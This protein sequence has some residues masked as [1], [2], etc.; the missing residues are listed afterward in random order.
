MTLPVIECAP[1]GPYLV[2]NLVRLRNS[3]G[4]N[5]A[6]KPVAALCRCGRSSTKPYCDGTHKTVGF[7]GAR[8]KGGGAPRASYA[9]RRLTIH[10]NRGICAH[11]GY[12]TEGVRAVFASGREPWI[13]P[14]GASVEKIIAVIEQCPS[15]ALS[16]S[17]DGIE[18]RDQARAPSI[19][20]TESGPY[21]VVGGAQLVGAEITRGASTEH[22]TLCRCGAS[23]NKPFCDGSHWDIGFKDEAD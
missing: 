21:A 19:T 6:T 17:L 20:V 8:G 14:D 10:D 2:K 15:G 1:D 13:D 23:K 5:L 16:Y 9:G 4:E 18:H 3:R 22:F 7:S 11:A 12:C